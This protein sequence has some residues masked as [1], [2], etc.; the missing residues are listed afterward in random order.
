MG[1]LDSAAG[2]GSY[3]RAAAPAPVPR[4]PASGGGAARRPGV[5][6]RLAR[7]VLVDKVD[8]LQWIVT[9]AAFFFVTILV[10]AFL[11]GSLVVENPTMLL[12][13][14]RA[15]GGGGRGG[16]EAVLPR[17]LGGLETGEG[18]TFEPTRLREK[19][20]R[21]RSADAQCLAELGRPVKRVGAR[22]PRLAL[23]NC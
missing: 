12:P 15:S 13:S 9:A 4:A 3:K 2:S 16:T 20:A 23:V 6:S 18:L 19:W 17:G 14:R 8:F 7:F 10:Y 21:E 1:S 5:R 11:P 22:K